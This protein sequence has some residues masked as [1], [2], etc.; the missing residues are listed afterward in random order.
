MDFSEAFPVP[1]Y[2][3]TPRKH[4][5]APVLWY[6]GKGNALAKLLPL[7]PY[8]QFYCEPFGGAG[9]ILLNRE[10]S[11][12]ELLNDLHGDL[13]NL[14]RHIQ[15]KDEDLIYRLKWTLYSRDEFRKALKILKDPEALPLDRAWAMFVATNQG[16]SGIYK[17]EGNWSRAVMASNRGMAKTT[18]NQSIAR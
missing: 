2:P 3:V 17:T 7:I 10:P 18:S 4:L 12:V 15:A 5:M 14:Y 13:I 1:D 16:F 9:T 11:P 6:G 8:G